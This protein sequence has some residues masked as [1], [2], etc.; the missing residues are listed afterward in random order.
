M[1]G[2]QN[3][4]VALATIAQTGVTNVTDAVDPGRRPRDAEA[5]A[6]AHR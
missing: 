2:Q 5:D 6:G 4:A 3:H 1:A